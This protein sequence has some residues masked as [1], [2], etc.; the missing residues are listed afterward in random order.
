MKR[1]LAIGLCLLL[2]GCTSTPDGIEPVK[3]FEL[4]R[5]LGT[6]YEIARLDHR[7]ERGL[8]QVSAEYAMRDD[9]G[10]NVTNRG[11]NPDT[12]EWDEAI[13][14]A[15]FVSAAST[16]HLKVSFFGPFYAS[17]VIFHLDKNEYQYALITGPDRDYFWL[18]SRQ[19]NLPDAIL[20]ELLEKAEAAGFNPKDFIYVNQ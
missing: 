8:E 11:F 5:Y 9:G 20:N 1:V 2:Q 12:G 13:G 3:G 14:K 7:F 4:Q 16:G 6:W 10:I 19:K 15:Y 18:L 17:Y